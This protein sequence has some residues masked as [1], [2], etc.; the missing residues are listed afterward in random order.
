ML[1]G[2]F[3]LLSSQ[4]YLRVTVTVV[5][6]LTGVFFPFI[7]SEN[8]ISGAPR[9]SRHVCLYRGDTSRH[10]MCVRSFLFERVG[11]L[12]SSGTRGDITLMQQ[13]TAEKYTNECG[14]AKRS[15]DVSVC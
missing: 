1:A 11:R 7:Q 9:K 15:N 12:Q 14:Y 3:L 4:N 5:V 10:V 2:G 6:A 13:A 8:T